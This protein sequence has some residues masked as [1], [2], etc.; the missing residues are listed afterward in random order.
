MDD[1]WYTARLKKHNVQLTGERQLVLSV[2]ARNQQ[3][4][5]TVEEIYLQAHDEKPSIG[6]ATVYRAMNLFIRYGIL[7][8]FDFGEGRARYEMVPEPGKPGHHHHLICLR[9]RKIINYDDF[10]EAERT[11]LEIMESGL[12]RR[13][14]F[15]IDDHIIHFYGYCEACFNKDS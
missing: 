10:M 14:H 13:Y 4:H 1:H 15:H 3:R 11:F 5:L 7:H 2:L 12:A 6:M 9:C 8:K